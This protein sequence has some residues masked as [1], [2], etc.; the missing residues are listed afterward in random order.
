MLGDGEPATVD[1]VR[2]L[3]AA[4]ENIG[5]TRLIRCSGLGNLSRG[6]PPTITPREPHGTPEKSIKD[7]GGPCD[8]C[9]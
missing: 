4:K 3:E 9:R 7:G 6:S 2:L 8:S 1:V 5:R